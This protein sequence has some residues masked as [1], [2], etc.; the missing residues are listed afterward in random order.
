LADNIWVAKK[1]ENTDTFCE[2][3]TNGARKVAIGKVEGISRARGLPWAYE[4]FV[5]GRPTGEV[6]AEHKCFPVSTTWSLTDKAYGT[7]TRLI[8]NQQIPWS[9]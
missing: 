4:G 7:H 2:D 1:L 6:R 5:R 3:L 8:N 9:K